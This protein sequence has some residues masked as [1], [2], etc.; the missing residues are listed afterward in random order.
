L[1]DLARF[2]AIW[3]DDGV[4]AISVILQPGASPEE[5]AARFQDELIPLQQLQIQP[6]RSLRENALVVFDQTFA[7]T[8]SLQGLA[9]LVAFIGVLSALMS[10]QLEKSR[11]FGVLRAVGMTA[12]QL[13]RLVLL[14]TG[15][16]GSVAGLLSIPTGIVLSLILIYIINRRA[17]GWTLQFQFDV[18]P[19][20]AAL[21]IALSAAIL[22]G[23]YP[24]LRIA[25]LAPA[26]ALRG[27]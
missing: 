18:M 14:E 19:L 9:T 7:I 27:E 11:E 20:I 10:L 17:F 3:G 12:G 22:A 2:R 6:N 23:L 25:R 21:V 4:T 24:A 16:M 26:D 15:L 8:S 13:R 5:A 1:R